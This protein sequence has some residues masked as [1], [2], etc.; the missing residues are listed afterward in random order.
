VSTKQLD[1]MQ[2][3]FQQIEQFSQIT[4]ENNA[5]SVVAKFRFNEGYLTELR[6]WRM[7][8]RSYLSFFF[9]DNQNINHLTNVE[10]RAL[11]EEE[12]SNLS[13][14]DDDAIV[15]LA[16]LVKERDEDP[17]FDLRS[18]GE[19]FQKL[20]EETDS[21][22]RNLERQKISLQQQRSELLIDTLDSLDTNN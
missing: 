7:L 19:K 22:L 17:K 9:N 6:K 20:Y 14:T 12:C 2:A 5:I 3:T 11:L 10:L 4:Q 16:Q 13:F 1:F 8:L 21:L 18:L 15:P